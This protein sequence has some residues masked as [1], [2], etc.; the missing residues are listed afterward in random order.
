MPE[1]H[2]VFIITAALIGL[3]VGAVI[4]YVLNKSKLSEAAAQLALIGRER[5]GERESSAATT[6]ALK[7]SQGELHALEITQ[8]QNQTHISALSEDNARLKQVNSEATEKVATLN[9]ELTRTKEL[10]STAKAQLEA[11]TQKADTLNRQLSTTEQ[12]LQQ[13]RKDL[14]AEKEKSAALDKRAKGL[15][16]ETT[17]SAKNA[18]EQNQRLEQTQNKLDHLQE[19]YTSLSTEHA[20]LTTSLAERET[21][22][23]EKVAQ[24]E[25]SKQ[26]LSKEFKNLA[27]KIFEE[28]GKTFSHNN[29]ES[30]DTML[31]PFKAQIEGFQT[32]INEVH[33]ASTKGHTHLNAEI[34]KVLD[35]GLKM[36]DEATNL[37]SAL[38]G[39]SQ[40]RGA[41][42]EA[43]LERTLE[44]SGLMPD[45]HYEKQSAFK[46][47]EG[48]N[49]Q[50]D[51]IIRLPGD[52]H[53]IIDSKVGLVAYDRAIS[54]DNDI[55]YTQAMDEHAKAVK[56]HIDDLVKKD[57]TNLIGVR[58]PNFVLMFMPIEPAYIEALKHNKDLF[59]YGYDKG[60]VMVSHTTLLP[61]L[62]TVQ[63]LW[64]MEQSNKEAREISDS[65]GHIYNN[66]VTIAEKLNKLGNSLGT[67]SNHYND[68][69]KS[70]VGKQGLYG[71]VDRFKQVSAKASKTMPTLEPKHLDF[72]TE[73]LT[74]VAEPID[75]T[76]KIELNKPVKELLGEQ[77]V[78]LAETIDDIDVS[79]EQSEPAVGKATAKQVEDREA[80]TNLI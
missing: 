37:T 6:E 20:E 51:F 66:V 4:T 13:I 10:F 14:S 71:K 64:A 36:S 39:D 65:A 28:K 38:K 2:I 8:G 48:K 56:A 3:F 11:E 47:A 78:E 54:A 49:K 34:K 31:Q 17:A 32:R 7:Q 58:S 43:Q 15:E 52:K 73:K 25:E 45:A 35:V 18:T 53:I 69:V 70:L 27:N 19:R 29:K 57:Y 72:E 79:V 74:L 63:N 76:I 26:S 44:M 1:Q 33:D 55:A 12:A 67:V 16:V 59:T 61:I 41:W 62:R 42:G 80:Q 77:V 5:D 30:I 60:V 68:T 50:T 75:E 24:L 21:S 46:D 22:H 40:K 9:G 23:Q